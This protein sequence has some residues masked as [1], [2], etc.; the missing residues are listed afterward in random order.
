MFMLTKI[1]SGLG[2]GPRFFAKAHLQTATCQNLY[3]T[4]LVYCPRRPTKATSPVKNLFIA[5]ALIISIK[6]LT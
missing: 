5:I 2:A 6:S 4:K 1:L 3:F